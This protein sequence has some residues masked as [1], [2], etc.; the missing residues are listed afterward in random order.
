[1]QVD[2]FRQFWTSHRKQAFA[3]VCLALSCAAAGLYFHRDA[4]DLSRLR[5]ALIPDGTLDLD[6]GQQVWSASDGFSGKQ[7]QNQWSYKEWTGMEYRDL[8]WVPDQKRWRGTHRYTIIKAIVQ[9]PGEFDSARVWTAPRSGIVQIT[10]NIHKNDTL[11]GNG[12]VATVMKNSTPIWGPRTLRFD[13]HIGFNLN[14]VTNVASGDSI[15]FRL[16]NNGNSDSDTTAWDPVVRFVV[17]PAFWQTQWF[18]AAVLSGS[19]AILLTGVTMGL[20]LRTR[21]RR[22]LHDLELQRAREAERARIAKDI[23]DDLGANLTQIALLSELAQTDLSEPEQARSHI[24]QIFSAARSL[25]R[26][27]DEIVW[28][29]NPANDTLESFLN[30][31]CEFVQEYLGTAGVR[32]RLD[33]PSSIPTQPLSTPVRHHLYLAAKEA[34]HNVVKHAGASEVRFALKIQ[35]KAFSLVIEDNGRGFARENPAATGNGLGNMRKR[36]E[37]IGGRFGQVSEPGRGT[38]TELTVPLS[39]NGNG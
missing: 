2:A 8:I 12:V 10:G 22:R 21:H 15:Y 11:K 36:L 1:M 26:S 37:E 9:H 16:S 28:A 33:L 3:F 23:H 29:V 32:C 25:T 13:D 39:R 20:V 30:Y 7:G 34:I 18:V 19:G 4:I 14:V 17:Q 5:A 38:R 31:I 35:D 6:I 24:N 27:L